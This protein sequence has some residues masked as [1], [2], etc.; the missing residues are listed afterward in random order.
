M[1]SLLKSRKGFT[2]IELMVVISIIAILITIALPR[3][4]NARRAANTAKIAADLRTIESAINIYYAK[5]NEYPKTAALL[6]KS[7]L[8]TDDVK[9]FASLPKP[10]TGEFYF[11]TKINGDARVASGMMREYSIFKKED[12]SPTSTT[13]PRAGLMVPEGT[14]DKEQLFS[15][16]YFVNFKSISNDSS[17]SWGK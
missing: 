6:S 11:S 16:E 15:L 12:G 5:H 3:F 14:S 17:P 2:L 9:Y 1:L 4:V 7:A 13:V 10:P 8:F